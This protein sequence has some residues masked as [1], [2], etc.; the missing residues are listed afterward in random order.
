MHFPQYKL[1]NLV[2]VGKR[3]LKRSL[4][5][6]SPSFLDKK[7]NKQSP[8]P[9]FNQPQFWKN[10]WKINTPCKSLVSSTSPPALVPLQPVRFHILNR[11]PYHKP[12]LWFVRKP[13]CTCIYRVLCMSHGELKQKLSDTVQL[14]LQV[15]TQS[16]QYCVLIMFYNEARKSIQLRF[17]SNW[18]LPTK[19]QDVYAH[20]TIN[21][22]S[23]IV[24]V[25]YRKCVEFTDCQKWLRC[26]LYYI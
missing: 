23:F 17:L 16:N 6:H 4:T 7:K 19:K 24:A 21:G 20:A 3:P 22:W 12:L 11:G 26:S 9:R 8:Y 15:D 1:N 25:T 2:L 14:V 13:E 10:L 5:M 18:S